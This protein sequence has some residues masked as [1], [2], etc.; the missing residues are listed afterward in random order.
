MHCRDAYKLFGREILCGP[1]CP[2]YKTC[3]YIL[4][5]DV[6]DKTAKKIMREMVRLAKKQDDTNRVRR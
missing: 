3:P 2:L 6:A 1:E 5:G 4:L